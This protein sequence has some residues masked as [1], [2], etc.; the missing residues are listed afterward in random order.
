MLCTRNTFYGHIS[1]EGKSAIYVVLFM[2]YL[3]GQSHEIDQALFDIPNCS[4]PDLEPG[5]VL[6]KIPEATLIKY[7]KLENSWRLMQNTRR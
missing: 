2:D 7:K 5:L 3:K 1:V 4:T 6:Q